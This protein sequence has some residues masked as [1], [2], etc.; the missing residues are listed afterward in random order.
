MFL[1]SSLIPTKHCH[2]KLMG[3]KRNDGNKGGLKG[4]KENGRMK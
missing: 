1:E 4:R 3:K 2:Q